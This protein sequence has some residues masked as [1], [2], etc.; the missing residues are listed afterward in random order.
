MK[1]TFKNLNLVIELSDD[2]IMVR[3]IKTGMLLRAKSYRPAEA[4]EK[5]QELIKSYRVKSAKNILK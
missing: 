3:D 4:V 5:F 2:T 1:E